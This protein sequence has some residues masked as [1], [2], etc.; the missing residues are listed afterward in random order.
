LKANE[1]LPL[2]CFAEL[3][4]VQKDRYG[5]PCDLIALLVMTR[6]PHA[7][8]KLV[9]FIILL[10][11]S[12]TL[13]H[14]IHGQQRSHLLFIGPVAA[15]SFSQETHDNIKTT[16]SSY[17]D[18]Y[19]MYHGI[20]SSK[21][22]APTLFTKDAGLPRWH[23]H[24]PSIAHVATVLATPTSTLLQRGSE[25]ENVAPARVIHDKSQ[26]KW[27]VQSSAHQICSSTRTTDKDSTAP[28]S[29]VWTSDTG[30]KSIQVLYKTSLL[31]E[32]KTSSTSSKPVDKED[33]VPA[34]FRRNPNKRSRANH[35]LQQVLRTPVTSLLIAVNV[36]IAFIY[37]NRGTNPSSVSK[38]YDKIVRDG[39]YWRAFTGATAHF[40][41][42]HLGFN[43]EY[44]GD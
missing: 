31:P 23:V 26:R 21:N 5:L 27:C 40:E 35:N 37:W 28:P 2:V 20:S 1:P 4:V 13:L 9:F 25:H 39:E 22:E 16:E 41:P 32:S 44:H 15:S 29:G 8:L 18:L 19:G 17:N 34:K 43:S 42:L 36:I 6:W 7:L 14:V 38:I 24:W 33:G 3:V 10:P 11:I 12:V 30:D